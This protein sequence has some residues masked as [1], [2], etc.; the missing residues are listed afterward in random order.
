MK[1][2]ALFSSKD[3][4]KLKCRLLLFLFGA[5]R[6]KVLCL[7]FIKML[8]FLKYY[9]QRH[10][11]LSQKK[12]EELLQCT[13]FLSKNISTFDMSTVDGLDPDGLVPRGHFI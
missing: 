6:V 3:K 7:L 2:Q 8:N 13:F 9:M 5:L 4:K 10:F 1:N 12:C 11:H